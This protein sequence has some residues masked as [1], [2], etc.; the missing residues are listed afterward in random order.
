MDV[1]MPAPA[2][3]PQ[4]VAVAAPRRPHRYR[5]GTVALREIRRY[6][7]STDALISKTAMRR[8]I[9]EIGGDMD[10][11]R[12]KGEALDAIHEAAESYIVDLFANAGVMCLHASRVTMNVSDVKL[13]CR[14]RG[15]LSI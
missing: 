14:I 10:G 9:R 13:A 7:T 5:P 8:I 2:V 12:F 4:A 15:K 1:P 6:Q 3:A 11:K